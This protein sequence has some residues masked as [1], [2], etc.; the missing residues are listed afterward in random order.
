MIF[1]QKLEVVFKLDKNGNRNP[2]NL[3]QRQDLSR[4]IWPRVPHTKNQLPRLKTVA[5]SLW[6][7]KYDFHQKPEVV[8]KLDKNGNRKQLNLMQRRYIPN[9]SLLGK[10]LWLTTFGKENMIFHQKREVV[11]KLDKKRE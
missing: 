4:G 8:F 10:K 2:L 3:I 7:R 6:E 11:F 9:F 5:Y 1:H